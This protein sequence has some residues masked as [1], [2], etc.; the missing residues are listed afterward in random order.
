[1]LHLVPDI[2]YI[3]LIYSFLVPWTLIFEQYIVCTSRLYYI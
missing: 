2:D 3:F 1:M